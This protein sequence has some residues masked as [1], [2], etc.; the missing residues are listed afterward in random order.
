MLRCYECKV[1]DNTMMYN[2]FRG[3]VTDVSAVT[4]ALVLSRSRLPPFIVMEKG[5]SLDEYLMR[6]ERPDLGNCIQIVIHVVERVSMVHAAGLA[7]RDIK[8]SNTL[9]LRSRNIWTLI[10]FGSAANH[11]TSRSSVVKVTY[12]TLGSFDL[13]NGNKRFLRGRNRCIG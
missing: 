10:D 13:D 2:N 1:F 5:E 12:A 9:F 7:H 6:S 11:G 4:N 8:P 3:D